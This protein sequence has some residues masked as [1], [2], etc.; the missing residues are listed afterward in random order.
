MTSQAKQIRGSHVVDIIDGK[1]LLRDV[2]LFAGFDP[3]LD[4][5]GSMG[6]KYPKDRV[7]RI[8]E[9][10]T[11]FMERGQFP[12]IVDGHE[13]KPGDG[14]G[15]MGHVV[16]AWMVER[17]NGTPVIKGDVLM[18][19]DVFRREVLSNRKPRRSAE[20]W[21][22]N[23]QL[24]EVALLDRDTP[25][26]P[27]EDTRFALH[28]E[29]AVFCMCSDET[30]FNNVDGYIPGMEPDRKDDKD[31]SDQISQLTTQIEALNSQIATLKAEK[32]KHSLTLT[33]EREQYTKDINSMS[34]T[35]RQLEVDRELDKL[36]TQGYPI[37]K[38]R[39]QFSAELMAC[40][41]PEARAQKVKFWMATMSA[42]P[43][44][45]RHPASAQ[46]PNV[47][48]KSRGP[49]KEQKDRFVREADGDIQKYRAL[50]NST[51]TD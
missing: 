3:D 51:F 31:M 35:L 49:T 9:T 28:G 26:R 37:A 44:N 16:K 22:H 23:D 17:S 21:N 24:S 43:V 13:R 29:K 20:I 46:D 10:T 2:E 11:K 41:T 36:A 15:C 12:Q 40:P 50:V 32:D 34:T 6:A 38:Q 45:L 30:K 7:A 18:P 14:D 5:P 47:P 19:L 33:Q 25:G 42:V 27:I 39:D 1:A 48:G 4:K 8:L